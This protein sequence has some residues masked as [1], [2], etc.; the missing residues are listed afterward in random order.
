MTIQLRRQRWRAREALALRADTAVLLSALD[1]VE[2]GLALYDRTGEL[3]FE[4]DHLRHQLGG[5]PEHGPLRRALRERVEAEAAE[6]LT[7]SPTPDAP[8]APGALR[9]ERLGQW[10]IERGRERFRLRASRIGVD[11][12]GSG[13]TLLL[14]V[15][16]RT[17]PP[18]PSEEDLCARFSLTRQQAR[19]A[20]L[21]AERRSNEEI[22]RALRVSEHTARNHTRAVLQRLGVSRRGEVAGRL[23]EK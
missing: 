9:L 3:L 18:P 16:R 11:L 4:S 14:S 21:L 15:E 13:P 12:C 1:Q 17:P 20:L 23:G 7:A 5:G 2:V 8:Q 6:A 10:E 22:A 19:V